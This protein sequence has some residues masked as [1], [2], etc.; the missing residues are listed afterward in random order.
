MIDHPNSV[1]AYTIEKLS[2]SKTHNYQNHFIFVFPLWITFPKT[3]VIL[4]VCCYVI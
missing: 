3:G 4:A 2:W 1:T